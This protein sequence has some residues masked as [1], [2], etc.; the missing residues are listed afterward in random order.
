MDF[1]IAY[2]TKTTY[3]KKK[4]KKSQGVKIYK[5]KH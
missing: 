2:T 3:V 4:K 1:G 5:K